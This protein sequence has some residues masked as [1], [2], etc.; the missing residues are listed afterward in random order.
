MAPTLA[1]Y[2]CTNVDVHTS[3]ALKRQLQES[4]QCD[5]CARWM[6]PSFGALKV[7]HYPDTH[8]STCL[9]SDISCMCIT[10][11]ASGWKLI[12]LVSKSC[13]LLWEGCVLQWWR[14]ISMELLHV[15]QGRHQ[16]DPAG[17]RHQQRA[18]HHTRHAGGALLCCMM[19]YLGNRLVVQPAACSVQGWATLCAS[20][21]CS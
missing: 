2:S 10:W 5:T 7:A 3:L 21:L 14:Q 19:S 4:T 18:L 6:L 15:M 20:L 12:K 11:K 13:S 8:C 9:L 17:P 1:I 16:Q